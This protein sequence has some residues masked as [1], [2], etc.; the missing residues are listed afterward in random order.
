[1]I[2]N[3][4]LSAL[5][6]LVDRGD[7]ALKVVP[8]VCVPFPSFPRTR[9]GKLSRDCVERLEQLGFVW[10]PFAVSWEEMFARLAAYKKAHGDCNVPDKW[11]EDP[12]FARWCGYQRWSHE[13]ETLSPDRIKRLEEIGFVWRAR[14]QQSATAW[15]EMFAGLVAYKEAHGDCNVPHHFEKDPKLGRWCGTQRTFYRKGKLSS[16]RIK[17]LEGIDFRFTVRKSKKK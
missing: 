17:R 1:M 10:D 6:Y 7:V 2:S 13:K 11:K 16:Y 9:K 3:V 12:A 4:R 8:L 14:S 5:L 15:E